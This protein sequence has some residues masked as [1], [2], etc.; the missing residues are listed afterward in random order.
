MLDIHTPE[1]YLDKQTVP[2]PLQKKKKVLNAPG[3]ELALQKH[4]NPVSGTQTE[5]VKP[6]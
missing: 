3:T 4:I 2:P 5:D 6:R 1:D